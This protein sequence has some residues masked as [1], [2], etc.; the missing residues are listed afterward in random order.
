MLG[1][2]MRRVA[3]PRLGL[4]P[5]VLRNNSRSRCV[6]RQADLIYI[7]VPLARARNVGCAASNF[8]LD[9]FLG[10]IGQAACACARQ[11]DPYTGASDGKGMGMWL[12]WR[13]FVGE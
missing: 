5:P 11:H 6:D 8:A 9:T 4:S 3:R 13:L 7:C 1:H 10:E 2:R 12:N